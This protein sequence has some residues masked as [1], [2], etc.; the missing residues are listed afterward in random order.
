[1]LFEQPLAGKV[2]NCSNGRNDKIAG[3][4]RFRLDAE[5]PTYSKP[6]KLNSDRQNILIR[7]ATI[8]LMAII[9][10]A[11]LVFYV[12][13]GRDDK[14]LIS[15]SSVPAGVR[16]ESSAQLFGY[17]GRV[18]GGD[19]F[20]FGDANELHYF[21]LTGVDCPEPGQPFYDQS[22]GFLTKNFRHKWLEFTS[23]GYDDWKREFGR[24]I[25][26]DENGNATD[27]GLSLIENGMAWY[28]G[29]EFEGAQAYRAA[30][31]KAKREKI[32]LWA[33]PNPVPPWEFYHR[34][35]ASVLGE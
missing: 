30:F 18:W 13:V 4:P 25:F 1:M 20:E 34:Q 32:G 28:D 26:V 31:E 33:Q 19:N 12:V 8:A 6:T 15:Y 29:N 9:M 16:A 27:I 22:K 21:Y 35:Q 5:R 2:A 24:A 14:M 7:R 10:V 17:L 3:R 11:I 23:D